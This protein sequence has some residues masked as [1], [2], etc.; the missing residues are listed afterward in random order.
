[1]CDHNHVASP[2]VMPLSA[3]R[4]NDKAYLSAIIKVKW[5]GRKLYDAE[6]LKILGE[7]SLHNMRPPCLYVYVCTCS[8]LLL[9]P[10]N[11]FPPRP[12]LWPAPILSFFWLF[13]HWALCRDRAFRCTFV[14]NIISYTHT[15]FFCRWC[16][17]VEQALHQ[18]WND[19][20]WSTQ[21]RWKR[22]WFNDR[23]CTHPCEKAKPKTQRSWL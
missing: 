3:M 15:F 14:A 17:R 6:I 13:P 19:M 20:R 7:C 5:N 11:F 16:P 10:N 21:T 18:F 22:S 1:M 12:N 2:N 4:K 9:L 23:G 8:P